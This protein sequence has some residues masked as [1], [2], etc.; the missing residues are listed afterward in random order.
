[1]IVHSKLSAVLANGAFVKSTDGIYSA[2]MQSDVQDQ[3]AEKVLR[4]RVAARQYGNHL[5]FIARHH[6]IPV[7]DHEVDRFLSA[8]P[9]EALILDV[10]G[11]WGWHW[12]RLA[13]IRP[14][15]GV[16]IVDFVRANLEHARKVLGSLVETQIGLMRADATNLPFSSAT[17]ASAG[18]DGIWTVQVFQSIP[19]FALACRE[20]HRVLK[21]GGRFAN[22]SL[23]ITPLN[24]MIYRLLGKR[25]HTEGM[26][27]NA[28]H[29]ARANDGQRQSVA[30]IFGG[31]VVD[32]Y[33]ECLFHPDL[34]LTF[35]GRF[36]SSMGK[37]DAGM[38]DFPLLGR[39]IARQRSFEA[40]K[41]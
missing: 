10:G 14:D 40:V 28:L 8:M 23:H 11:C 39:W 7:M 16:L 21:P 32:R 30:E 38:G 5:A 27:E 9:Q 26:V 2:P 33:T 36:G 31:E 13:Q 15:V 1:V 6:S 18:F 41:A 25:F 19:D 12:R 37:L 3:Q 17:A 34:R 20:A 29:L 4:E 22:Y 35:T 24:R